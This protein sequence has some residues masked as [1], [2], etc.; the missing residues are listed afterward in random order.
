MRLRDLLASD[1]WH[2]LDL[3]VEVFPDGGEQLVSMMLDG[4]GR[5]DLTD[6][7]AE[8]SLVPADA[9]SKG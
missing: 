1:G 4:Q 3:V 8:V 5:P 9:D 2:A 6:F 7:S